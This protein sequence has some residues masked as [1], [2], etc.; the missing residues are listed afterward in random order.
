[1]ARQP[2]RLRAHRDPS[3]VRLD[4]ERAAVPAD[5]RTLIPNF[6]A[7]IEDLTLDAYGDEE[8]L[9]GFLVGAEEALD[10]GERA[11]LVGIDVEVVDIDCG[12]DSRTG[13]TACVRRDGVTYEVALADLTF[14]PGSALGLVVRAD[15]RW[16]GR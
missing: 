5:R 4:R 12:P 2:T 14:A 3:D 10:R 15:R 7:V 16:L 6:D 13:L 9:S 1:M 11:S 8:Q